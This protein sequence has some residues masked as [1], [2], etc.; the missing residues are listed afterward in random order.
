VDQNLV[1][2]AARLL[3]F[4]VYNVNIPSSIIFILFLSYQNQSLRRTVV[5]VVAVAVVAKSGSPRKFLGAGLWSHIAG[6]WSRV[7]SLLLLL[8]S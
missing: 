8:S 7:A 1:F 2:C 5:A 3:E 6:L 4:P